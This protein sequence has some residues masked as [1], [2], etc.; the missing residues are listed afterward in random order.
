M[1]IPEQIDSKGKTFVFE[2]ESS[3]GNTK[4]ALFVSP[5]TIK[6]SQVYIIPKEEILASK[7]NLVAF[8]YKKTTN[9][10]QNLDFILESL[11][12]FLPLIIYL[13]SLG[14]LYKF[15]APEKLVLIMT[16]CVTIIDIFFLGNEYVGI[17]IFLLFLWCICI[18]LNKFTYR[19]SFGVAFV[20]IS[21]WLLVMISGTG[22]PQEKLNFW[23]YLFLVFG[24]VQIVLSES[25]VHK[26]IYKFSRSNL[27][28]TRK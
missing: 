8:L 24:T 26:R 14:F 16:T 12:F 5:S 3:D 9:N 13:L 19:I 1:G 10:V 11:V 25:Q 23:T 17:T 7:K 15:K 18:Y 20:L 22:V 28:K 2:I 27:S 6:I 4:N 21:L